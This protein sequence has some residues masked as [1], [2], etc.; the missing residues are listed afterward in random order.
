MKNLRNLTLSLVLAFSV[1]AIKAQG[2]IPN[3]TDYRLD[4]TVVGIKGDS[5]KLSSLKG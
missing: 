4:F 3:I 1:S 5:I 2:P